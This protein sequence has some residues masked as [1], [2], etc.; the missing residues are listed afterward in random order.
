VSLVLSSGAPRPLLLL[1]DLLDAGESQWARDPGR[2]VSERLGEHLWSR[3][4]DIIESVRDHRR[5]AVRSCHGIGKSFIASRTAAWWLEAF[6]PGE[7]FVCST[8]PTFEQVR[9]VLWR[10]I[11]QVHRKAGLRGRVNQTEWFI[12]DELVAFGRKPANEDPTAFQ[13]IHAPRVLV[14]MDEACGIDRSLWIAANSLVSNEASRILAI[15][16]PD[17]PAAYFAEV[18]RPDSGWNVIGISAFDT[19]NFTGEA[20]PATLSSGLI[21]PTYV[22]EMRRDCGEASAPYKSK[23]LGEFPDESDDG[24][25][26][27]HA[28]RACQGRDHVYT[29][30]DL[31]PVELGWD[32]GAGG[33]KSVVYER[34]GMV[35]GR[36]W[37]LPGSD[38]MAQ[39]GQVVH[40]IAETAATALKI[41]TIGIGH[42]AADRM[43]ELGREGTH[44]A[45]V[46]RVNVGEGSTRPD[47]FPK[48]R[49]QLWWEIARQLSTDGAWDLTAIDEGTVAQLTAPKYGLDSSGRV[50]VEPKAETKKRL[51]RSPD[52]AD[53]LILAYHSPAVRRGNKMKFYGRR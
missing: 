17:D 43:A 10:Y 47:R 31:L 23:V 50:K 1:A 25:V 9:A 20:V 24:V 3:Q 2:F 51:G 53:A 39:C 41:D 34:R 5:T 6:P 38:T 30:E 48:L 49:D 35:A 32:V 33:D 27:V 42:G 40:I 19:P 52:D 21:G 44:A 37:S 28:V 22:E 26:S 11:G 13:G 4:G 29:E 18:C 14:L 45:H 12:G 46:V 8:A 7:A 16:N 36:S 15:G